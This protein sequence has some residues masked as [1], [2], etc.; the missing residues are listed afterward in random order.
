VWIRKK[1]LWKGKYQSSL[2]L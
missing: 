2:S 1:Q